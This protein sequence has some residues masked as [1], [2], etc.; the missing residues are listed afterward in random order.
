MNDL[1]P[2]ADATRRDQRYRNRARSGTLIVYLQRFLSAAVNIAQM[3]VLSRLLTPAE[4]GVA[5]I[6]LVIYNFMTV[7]RDLG[8]SSA[9][10]QVD[11]LGAERRTALFWFSVAVTGIGAIL[12]VATAP[13]LAAV[14]RAPLTPMLWVLALAFLL[15]GLASQHA[16]SLRREI[17]FKPVALAEI[18]GLLCG[19]AL[20]FGLALRGAGAWSLVWGTV[21]QGCVTGALYWSFAGWMP[22]RPRALRSHLHLVWFGAGASAFQ[23]SNYLAYNLP[24]ALIG[25]LYDPATM[26]QFSRAQSLLMFPLTFLLTPFMAVQFPLLCR[27]AAQPEATIALY[28]RILTLTSVAFLPIG[29]IASLGAGDIVAFLFGP[30]W[31][32]AAVMVAYLG[33]AIAS[34]GVLGPFSHFMISQGRVRELGFWGMFD[35]AARGGSAAL[36]ALHS[37]EAAAAAFGFVSLLVCAPLSL[38]LSGRRGPVTTRLQL[39]AIAR[40]LPAVAAS[41]ATALAAAIVIDRL[42][43]DS[44]LLNLVL[45]V[46]PTAAVWVTVVL[47]DRRIR[48]LLLAEGREHRE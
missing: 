13:L 15:V 40:S 9:T 43:T 41:G 39:M 20:T 36:G 26:G 12:I 2:H 45:L 48:V 35:F 18:A 4:Y 1:T 7:M 17:A 21:L 19:V 31:D 46:V 14:F 23:L 5:A 37:P 3:V 22:R 30:Q 11:S 25:Y 29:I 44:V 34:F 33:P 47:T 38:L 6:V 16:A 8:L 42:Q 24:T 27:F 28:Q 32:R 10:I